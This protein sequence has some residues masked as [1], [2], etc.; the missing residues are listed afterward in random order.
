MHATA[1][2]TLVGAVETLIKRKISYHYII[3]KDGVVT[4]CVPFSEV[5]FHAGVSKGPEGASVNGYSVG[6][7]FVNLNDGRDPYTEVQKQAAK[8]LVK[9]LMLLEPGLRYLTSHRQISWPRKNDPVGLG[10]YLKQLAK[11]CGLKYWMRVGVPE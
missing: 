11:E 1:G 6:I 4:Q 3:D 8:E 7:S 9:Q 10:E 5:A 2:R